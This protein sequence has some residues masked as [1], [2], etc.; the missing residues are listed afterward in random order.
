M[1]TTNGTYQVTVDELAME[2]ADAISRGHASGTDNAFVFS[3][4]NRLF[5]RMCERL[6]G[7]YITDL[8]IEQTTAYEIN[9][10]INVAFVA[11]PK[12]MELIEFC[13]L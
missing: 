7:E 1:K 10:S 13:N 3:N 9:P 11:T 6:E 8:K 12:L 5:V 4:M 2:F